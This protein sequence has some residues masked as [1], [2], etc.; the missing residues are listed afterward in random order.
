MLSAVV[1]G[2]DS[3]QF[4]QQ[5]PL[6]APSVVLDVLAND[7]SAAG[8]LTIT[9]VQPPLYGSVTIQH[10]SISV[11]MGMPPAPDTLLCTPSYGFTGTVT[12]TYTVSDAAG[13][14]ATATVTLMIPPAPNDPPQVTNLHL[15]SD[16]GTAGDDVTSDPTVTGTLAD[17]GFN[18]SGNGMSMMSSTYAVQIDFGGDGSVEQTVSANWDHT[19]N[20]SPSSYD[21]SNGPVTIQARAVETVSNGPTLYGDWQTLTFTDQ[22]PANDPPQ[23]TSLRLVND[24]GTAGDQITGDPAVTALHHPPAAAQTAT[25]SA[26]WPAPNGT[27]FVGKV[28]GTFHVPATFQSECHWAS[29]T[30]RSEVPSRHVTGVLS[31]INWKTGS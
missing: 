2:N 22:A 11:M 4:A 1:V 12:F 6:A 30:A 24:T 28:A 27:H 20:Y 9:S 25:A 7:S 31:Q 17:G 13:D 16:T 14:Q 26:D 18:P 21:L 19:F 29:A 23:V 15:V 3:H 8:D 5:S 10:D